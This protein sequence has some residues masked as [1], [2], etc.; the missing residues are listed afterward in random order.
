[1]P[2]ASRRTSGACGG[3]DR[4]E[5]SAQCRRHRRSSRHGCVCNPR[6]EVARAAR[7]AR[8]SGRSA[9]GSLVSRFDRARRVGVAFLSRDKARNIPICS[10]ALRAMRMRPKHLRK[11]AACLAT[12]CVTV[13]TSRRSPRRS[14]Y[15]SVCWSEASHRPVCSQRTACAPMRSRAIRLA[16][17]RPP[18]QRARCSFPMP[19]A[20]LANAR[21]RWSGSFHQ[22][23]VS[24]VIAGLTERVVREIVG[25]QE[26]EGAQVYV[27]NV[28]APT[29]CVIAGAAQAVG[30]ALDAGNDA[31]ARRA[32]R[33][34]VAVPSIA[35][36]S[37]PFRRALQKCW[38]TSRS[39]I[40][41]SPT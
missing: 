24:G 29:Q 40:H 14:T 36:C 33:L 34:D 9:R 17:S 7:V 28:N 21:A 27:A 6:C 37:R 13:T 25:A 32:D 23:M 3:P 30:R 2:L 11:R 22:G 39:R 1:M 26:R 35:P 8:R 16:A 19:Y 15:N 38:P 20:S 18:S 4:R 31:G 10:R 12:M 5:G 41:A